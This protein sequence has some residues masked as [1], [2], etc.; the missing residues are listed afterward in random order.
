M[1]LFHSHKFCSFCFPG[2]LCVVSS[3]DHQTT[4]LVVVV[5]TTYPSLSFASFSES[6]TSRHSLRPLYSNPSPSRQSRQQDTSLLDFCSRHRRHLP[7]HLRRRR[8]RW[9]STS[10][11]LLQKHPNATTYPTNHLSMS[12]T[13][14]HKCN[15]LQKDGSRNAFR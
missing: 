13:W 15:Q 9:N 10:S 5:P 8:R 1:R 14:N 4:C 12:I 11:H 7:R 6:T 3:F 2:C